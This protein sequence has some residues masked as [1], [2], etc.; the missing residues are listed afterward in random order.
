M[1]IG[2][3]PKNNYYPTVPINVQNFYVSNF[4]FGVL[5]EIGSI[6]V[7]TVYSLTIVVTIS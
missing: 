6:F 7:E 2:V 4:R 5:N 3:F 1:E